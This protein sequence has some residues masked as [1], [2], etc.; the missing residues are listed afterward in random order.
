MYSELGASEVSWAGKTYPEIINT[1]ETPGSI[2]VVPVGSIEQHGHHLPVAT[3]TILV[4]AVAHLGAER[5]SDELPIL[6]TPPVW[7]GYS[8]HHMPFGGTMTVEH[9]TLLTLLEEVADTAL[10]N[11]F[12]A[13]LFLNG[14]GG[15]ASLISSAV[16][17]VGV[18]HPEAEILGLTYFQL[19]DSFIDEI[20]E[21][22]LGGMAH[23]GEF[24][25]S[26]M[27]HLRPDLVSDGDATYWEEPYDRAGDDLLHGGP[28]SVYRTFDEYS[29]T[30]AIGDPELASAEKGEAIYELLGDELAVLLRTVHDQTT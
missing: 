25:T 27:A 24:E 1:A 6:L 17:T 16:S 12:D 14:H 18:A 5:V 7:T 19:A 22:E 26:L 28:L 8:P 15:N 10:E 11:G 4:D 30:G 13:L 9:R 29:E 21:S 23:G 2:L 20:R 3:D